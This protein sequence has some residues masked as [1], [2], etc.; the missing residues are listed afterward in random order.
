MSIRSC[1]FIRFPDVDRYRQVNLVSWRHTTAAR[2][3]M[4]SSRSRLRLARLFSPCTFQTSTCVMYSSSATPRTEVLNR[5]RRASLAPRRW[6]RPSWEQLV[7]GS[8]TQEEEV[9]QDADTRLIARALRHCYGVP[10]WMIS[11]MCTSGRSL[12][13]LMIWC[14]LPRWL[15]LDCLVRVVGMQYV[16][17]LRDENGRKWYYNIENGSGRFEIFLHFIH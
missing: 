4:T 9:D 3:A 1:Y 13:L 7:Q 8:P 16:F 15:A 2:S 14:N 11:S 12:H 10:D 6:C 17:R 5:T